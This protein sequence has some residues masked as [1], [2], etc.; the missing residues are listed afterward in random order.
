MPTPVE[1][2]ALYAVLLRDSARNRHVGKESLFEDLECEHSDQLT[3]AQMLAHGSF[4]D[5]DWDLVQ[6]LCD[7]RP[8]IGTAHKLYREQQVVR[9]EGLLHAVF[10][11]GKRPRGQWAV[12]I[13]ARWREVRQAIATFEAI[14]ITLTT[15]EMH[16]IAESAYMKASGASL[17]QTRRS[18]GSRW[19]DGGYSSA[20]T[21]AKERARAAR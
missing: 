5:L 20:E 15:D 8:I 10:P 16:D 14:G 2:I 21:A 3:Y 7:G 11:R 18:F 13:C 17:E 19:D 9:A 6:M 4:T 12:F 1:R